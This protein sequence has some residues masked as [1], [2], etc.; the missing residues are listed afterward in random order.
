MQ[1][2]TLYTLVDITN[3]G[4]TNPNSKD[5]L[6]YNQQQNL[7][8]VIQLIGMRSQPINVSV[9]V[10]EAQDIVDLGFGNAFKGLHTVWKMEFNSEHTDVFNKNGNF[11]YFL[12]TEFEGAVFTSGLAETVSF[13][14]NLFSIFDDKIKNTYFTYG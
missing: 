3:S 6:G 7:N 2:Y 1:K 13:K 9:S 12:E 11:V 5:I 4:I 14:Q 10:K 8:T